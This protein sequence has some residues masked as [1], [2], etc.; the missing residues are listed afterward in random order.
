VLSTSNAKWKFVFFHHPAYSASSKH[1]STKEVQNTFVPLFEK[2]HVDACF[3]GHDHDLQHSHPENS[4][5]EYFGTGGGSET[6]PVGTK[7]FTKFSQASL[8]FG[9]VSLT[10]ST[11]RLSFVNEKGERLYTYEIHK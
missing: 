2:Y 11:M 5:I 1:G 3:S 10:Q 7:D 9:A 4:T 8:G 6:R